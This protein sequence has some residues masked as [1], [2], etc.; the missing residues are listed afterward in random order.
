MMLVYPSLDSPETVEGICNQKRLIGLRLC[1]GCAES[2]LVAKSL[3]I[4]FCRALALL[5]LSL[6]LLLL[7]LLL[8]M[9]RLSKDLVPFKTI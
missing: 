2:S 7:L 5:W 9:Q 3:I 1:A 8:F 4:G 6:L